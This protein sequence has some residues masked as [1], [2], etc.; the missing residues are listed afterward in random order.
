MGTRLVGRPITG[1]GFVKSLTTDDFTTH[2]GIQLQTISGSILPKTVIRYAYYVFIFSLPFEGKIGGLSLLGLILAGVT[3]LQ[4]RL[5]LQPA[6]KAFW[7]FALYLAVVAALGFLTILGTEQDTEFTSELIRQL[8]ALSQL[9]VFVLIAYRLM[10]FESIAKRSLLILGLSCVLLAVLQTSGVIATEVHGRMT[11]FEDN[12]NVVAL[13]LSVGL[14][15][16]LGSAHARKDT[17]LKFRL[18]AWISSVV[19]LVA[20]VNTGS[21]GSQLALALALGALIMRTTTLPQ[22]VKTGLIVA[23]V[24]A[25]LGWAIYQMDAAR[26]RWETHTTKERSPA[27]TFLCRSPGRCF[28]RDPYLDGARSPI[29]MK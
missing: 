1:R 13:V 19:L 10:M 9:L 22:K 29:M 3:M 24:I 18:L 23:A 4:F 11:A 17:G 14:L 16:L 20:I 5:F 21:R 15:C 7:W 28:W 12:P 27:V 26:E 2:V 8:F 25:C 6:P